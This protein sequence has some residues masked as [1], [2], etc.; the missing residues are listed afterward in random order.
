MDN[1]II[2]T[3]FDTELV[4]SDE[5]KYVNSVIGQILSA[6]NKS[7][8]IFGVVPVISG[9]DFSVSAGFV[10]F[11]ATSDPTYINATG[12]SV[13]YATVPSQGGLALVNANCFIYVKP[14]LTYSLDNRTATVTAVIYSSVNPSDIGI[15]I[16]D[17]VDGN[18]E[19]FNNN[20]IS[21]YFSIVNGVMSF[22]SPDGSNLFL[23]YAV[24]DGGVT[25]T[26]SNIGSEINLRST[27]AQSGNYARSAT[28]ADTSTVNQTAAFLVA[29]LNGVETNRISCFAAMRALYQ[30]ATY[31]QPS[32]D[33]QYMNQVLLVYQDLQSANMGAN[34]SSLKLNGVDVPNAN[35]FGTTVISQDGIQAIV[36]YIPGTSTVVEVKGTIEFTFEQGSP[37]SIAV[38]IGYI[39]NQAGVLSINNPL[40]FNAQTKFDGNEI[41]ATQSLAVGYGTALNVMV[42]I[43]T[44]ALIGGVPFYFNLVGTH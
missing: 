14:Q 17:I 11:G 41:I 5:M 38:N 33:E 25:N 3:W 24:T 43:N 20:N 1:T 26:I 6:S 23:N 31:S 37:E 19:N 32:T 18:T 16:C 44:D 8:S 35:S 29:G 34:F 4:R 15:K 28:F 22:Q 12:S 30:M 2:N 9:S 36:Y 40:Y 13:L 21:N 27:S 39:L 42:V 10:F 7:T